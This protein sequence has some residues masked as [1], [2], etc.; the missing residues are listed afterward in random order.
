MAPAAVGQYRAAMRLHAAA[1]S[2][3]A[4]LPAQE[5]G[6]ATNL[7]VTGRI[8]EAEDQRVQRPQPRVAVVA[9]AT[10]RGAAGA[11]LLQRTTSTF[12]SNGG[13]RGEFAPSVTIRE[14]RRSTRPAALR[15]EFHLRLLALD[16]F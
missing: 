7:H 12:A 9:D 2:L 6:H 4:W 5:L 15:L 3:V 1:S 16:D 14:G 11:Q 8:A 10:T 13:P